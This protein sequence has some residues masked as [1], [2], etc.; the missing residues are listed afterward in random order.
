MY[1]AAAAAAVTP[2]VSKQKVAWA[3]K[4]CLR[5]S[6]FQAEMICGLYPRKPT[7]NARI[8]GFLH[9]RPELSAPAVN[10]SAKFSEEINNEQ[11][12]AMPQALLSS[13]EREL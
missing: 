1:V 7:V 2:K 12:V 5:Q 9:V 4:F 10:E 13:A 6:S 8:L 11:A 3:Y